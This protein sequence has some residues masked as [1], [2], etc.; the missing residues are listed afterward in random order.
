[1]LI[2]PQADEYGHVQAK[3]AASR[4]PATCPSHALA[5]SHVTKLGLRDELA[6][7]H[8]FNVWFHGRKPR[9]GLKAVCASRK[10]NVNKRQLDEKVRHMTD[11]S[12]IS[13]PE[14]CPSCV[15]LCA[16]REAVVFK[17]MGP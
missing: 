9:G 1:M 3:R 16:R 8:R 17:G 14:G 15:M 7:T 5:A 2:E 13:D 6:S 12:E 11:G 4:N 10:P